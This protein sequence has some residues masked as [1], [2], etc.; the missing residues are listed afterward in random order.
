MFVPFTG[1]PFLG[2]LIW[3]AHASFPVFSSPLPLNNSKYNH[4]KALLSES[5]S[6]SL[7]SK[8]LTRNNF[9]IKQGSCRQPGS[10]ARGT[11]TALA[12]QEGQPLL[13][14]FAQHGVSTYLPTYLLGCIAFSL[15]VLLRSVWSHT[16]VSRPLPSTVV[17]KPRS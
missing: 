8:P 12:R 6:Y 17:I 5:P 7:D 1:T 16:P 11:A 4:K 13:R 3:A 15:P 14:L 2:V 10:A 9:R